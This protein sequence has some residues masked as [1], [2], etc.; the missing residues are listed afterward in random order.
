MTGTTATPAVMGRAAVLVTACTLGTVGVA[1]L[2]GIRV[3]GVIDNSG[4]PYLGT[5]WGAAF[6][7]A[8]AL[9]IAARL[10]TD[11]YL[12]MVLEVGAIISL[13][14]GIGIYTLTLFTADPGNGWPANS[15]MT[16][17]LCTASSLNL[18]GRGVLV[19]RS[20]CRWLLAFRPD[21]LGARVLRRC[22]KVRDRLLARCMRGHR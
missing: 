7:F 17:A 2:L 3:S 4:D 14:G 5:V 6:V 18:A 1:Q 20:L 15:T 12:A 22:E 11:A 9:A 8:G 19:F 10:H 16:I 21:D 13:C